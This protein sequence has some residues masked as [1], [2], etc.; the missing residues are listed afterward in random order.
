MKE[1][2]TWSSSYHE[3]YGLCYSLDM[4][5]GIEGYGIDAKS[6]TIFM[7][8]K[9]E[10]SNIIG[11]GANGN[12]K[13]FFLGWI[14]VHEKYSLSSADLHSQRLWFNPYCSYCEHYFISK[15]K[16]ISES[17]KNKPC[18]KL[19]HI[20]CEDVLVNNMIEDAYGC[21]IPFFNTGENQK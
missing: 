16:I 1:N 9:E 13:K 18:G 19:F 10:K 7:R 21:K 6:L 4:N 11:F 17:T 15:K 2:L 5:K 14:L 8:F 20:E 12:G 3:T